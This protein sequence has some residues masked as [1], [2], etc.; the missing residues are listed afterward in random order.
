MSTGYQRS[1]MYYSAPNVVKSSTLSSNAPAIDYW[2]FYNGSYGASVFNYLSNGFVHTPDYGNSDLDIPQRF[3]ASA[4]YS[5]PCRA[6]LPPALNQL[7]PDQL[8]PFGQAGL[9]PL[10]LTPPLQPE[11]RIGSCRHGPVGLRK[12]PPRDR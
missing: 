7:P 3:I 11:A 9:R 8:L 4:G 6:L 5:R 10:P 1:G 12:Q 2:A